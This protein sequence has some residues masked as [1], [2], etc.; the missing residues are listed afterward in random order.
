MENEESEKREYRIFNEELQDALSLIFEYINLAHKIYDEEK[1]RQKQKIEDDKIKG[2]TIPEWLIRQDEISDRLFNA[3]KDAYFD[4]KIKYVNQL[5][6]MRSQEL[7][8]LRGVG[9]KAIQ[10][11]RYLL[12]KTEK[13]N[14]F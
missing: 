5:F 13:E 10:E 3:I 4:G 8:K 6:L 9:E 7:K 1:K 14:S 11:L 2:E 12:V